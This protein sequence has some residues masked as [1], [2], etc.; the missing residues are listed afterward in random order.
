MSIYLYGLAH[1]NPELTHKTLRAYLHMTGWAE[2]DAAPQHWHAPTQDETIL[3]P[4]SPDAP[5]P[6]RNAGGSR[7]WADCF[8]TAIETLATYEDQPVTEIT[9]PYRV[10]QVLGRRRLSATDRQPG[11]FTTFIPYRDVLNMVFDIPLLPANPMTIRE[12]LAAE[13]FRHWQLLQPETAAEWS[14]SWQAHI[15]VE[16]RGYAVWIE[17]VR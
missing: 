12:A 6:Q 4:E 11:A 7:D 5:L 13:A 17:K 14:L 10:L 1:Y 9:V 15:E 16:Y 3:L 8:Q 2:A